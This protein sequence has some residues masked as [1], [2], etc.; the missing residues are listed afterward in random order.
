VKR[1]FL[2]NAAFAVTILDFI[3]HVPLVS[4][5]SGYPDRLSLYPDRLSLYPEWLGHDS[6][7]QPQTYV[8]PETAITVFELLM[9]SGVSLET[10]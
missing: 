1:V 7:R 4:L 6:C 3:S 10:C 2:L 5:L 9:L 8:K